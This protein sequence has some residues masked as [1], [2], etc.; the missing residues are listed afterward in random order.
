MNQ[1]KTGTFK[2]MVF[3][4]QWDPNNSRDKQLSRLRMA[5]GSFHVKDF[6]K[7]SSVAEANASTDT[8]RTKVARVLVNKDLT[9]KRREQILGEIVAL[10]LFKRVRQALI[11]SKGQMTPA[12]KRYLKGGRSEGQLKRFKKCRNT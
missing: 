8:Q 12:L 3:R 6:P 2:N 7:L 5:R 11:N 1:W 4:N 10:S 9:E